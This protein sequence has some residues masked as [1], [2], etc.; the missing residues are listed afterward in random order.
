MFLFNCLAG[1]LR[2][3]DLQKL[4][5]EDFDPN[6]GQHGIIRLISEKG[7][8]PLM[9]P[10]DQTSRGIVDKY[11]HLPGSRLLPTIS[12]TNYR[13][14]I[15]ELAQISKINTPVTRRE[16]KGNQPI[17]TTKPKYKL[18]ST[19]TARRTYIN[20]AIQAGIRPEIVSQVTGTGLDIILNYYKG[21]SENEILLAQTDLL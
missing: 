8:K 3:S 9:I 1:G 19:H 16:V 12:A 17:E 21:V 4:R 20:L 2:V 14:Y 6:T 7:E 11:H 10:L 13:I 5:K 18:I 15:K